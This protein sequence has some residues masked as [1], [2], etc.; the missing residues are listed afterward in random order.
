M[1]VILEVEMP[2]F[3][4]FSLCQA[5]QCPSRW[6]CTESLIIFSA[7]RCLVINC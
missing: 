4:G 5:L 3:L 6:S 7:H 2:M 1:Q